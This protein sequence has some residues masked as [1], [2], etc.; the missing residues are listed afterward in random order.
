MEN[1]T[2]PDLSFSSFRIHQIEGYIERINLIE[3]PQGLLLFDSGCINDVKRIESYCRQVLH[4]P[5]SDIKL[6]AVTHIHPDHSGGAVPLRKKYR[7][8]VAAHPDVD[9][10]YKGAG[11]ALQQK[12]DCYLATAVAYRNRRKLEHILF[13]RRINP[14]YW[15][16]DGQS[17]PFFPDWKVLHVPGHTIHDLAF[18]HEQERIL[19]VADLICDVKGKPELPMPIVFPR[20]MARSY[21]LLAGL[22]ARIILRAHGDPIFTDDPAGLFN[23]MIQ[24]LKRPPTPIM[25]RVWRLSFYSPQA[26]KSKEP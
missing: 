4:R 16:G 17:F 23:T 15:L 20:Q 9:Q 6:V 3:Y 19:Y 22:P 11:G 26:R 24:L 8:P 21:Q 18:F 14:D 12:L 25:K 1:R 7:T 5:V 13:E 10:W 2:T